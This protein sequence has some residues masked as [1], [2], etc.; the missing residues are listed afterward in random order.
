MKITLAKDGLLGY[1]IHDRPRLLATTRRVMRSNLKL[2]KPFTRRT[3]ACQERAIKALE[4]A[5]P[6]LALCVGSWRACSL[7]ARALAN[8]KRPD[9]SDEDK[10][11]QVSQG[12]VRGAACGGMP[13]RADAL[14][15]GG[16]GKLGA[17]V[18]CRGD[19]RRALAQASCQWG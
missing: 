5:E 8:T 15:G 17:C 13:Q 4:A 10:S 18:S 2:G 3:A 14:L 1:T 11:A 7:L 16:G 6:P 19:G 9:D 12:H